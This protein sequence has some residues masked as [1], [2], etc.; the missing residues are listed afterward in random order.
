M[1]SV[2]LLSSGL[3]STVNLYEAYEK[4][5]IV[6][7]L[8][9]NYGQRAV[10]KEID[11]AQK[12]CKLLKL[13]HQIID[14]T[15]FSQVGKS[16]LIDKS[17]TVPTGQSVSIDNLKISTETASSVWVPNRNGVF[18][19]IAAAFAESLKAEVIIP[20]FNKEEAATFPDNSLAFMQALDHSFEYST[21][22][23]VKVSCYTVQFSKPEIVQKAKA[24]NI[25]LEYI[26][27]CYFD[28]KQWCGQCESCLRSKRAF[29]SQGLDFNQFAVK[30]SQV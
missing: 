30:S 17:K 12:L 20:G 23:K 24:L 14:I 27:P 11:R 3:D 10:L 28:Q 8:T 6:L 4:T 15:W 22:N 26:W 21:A 13:N 1:K 16:S 29:E 25:P 9:F 5:E 7:V 18:L 2:V 19:N